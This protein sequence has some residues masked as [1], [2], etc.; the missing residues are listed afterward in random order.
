MTAARKKQRKTPAAQTSAKLP[1]ARRRRARGLPSKQEPA[2][3]PT[4]PSAPTT[5]GFLIV[6]I[7]ASAGGL[8]AMEEFFRHIPPSSGMAFVVVGL[9]V[10]YE[11]DVPSGATIILTA[12]V[13]FFLSTALAR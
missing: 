3:S 8:E 5:L 4:L 13:T 10:S 12:A 6:G 9:I 11:L 7:G 1:G 2:P